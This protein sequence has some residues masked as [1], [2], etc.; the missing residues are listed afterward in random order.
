MDFETDHEA[1]ST[2]ISYAGRD[3][4]KPRLVTIEVLY[5]YSGEWS[6]ADFQ[7]LVAEAIQSIPPQYR[8]VAKVEL[9]DCGYDSGSKFSISYVGPESQETVNERIRRCE[10]YVNDCRRREQATFIRLKAKFGS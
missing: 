1:R 9:K 2:A 10:E 5:E 8:D 4:D 3:F 6:L 7:R